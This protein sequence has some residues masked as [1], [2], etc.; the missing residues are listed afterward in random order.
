[1][2]S[3]DSDE[4][5]SG[6]LGEGTG[7]RDDD[8]DSDDDPVKKSVEMIDDMVYDDIPKKHVHT[9]IESKNKDRVPLIL[10]GKNGKT[11]VVIIRCHNCGTSKGMEDRGIFIQINKYVAW[12]HNKSCHDIWLALPHGSGYE[13]GADINQATGE[14]IIET[15]DMP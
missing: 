11:G 12:F 5:I 3:D 13:T 14:E 8:G 4:E 9:P 6:V 2:S 7:I 15:P 1:M 10:I